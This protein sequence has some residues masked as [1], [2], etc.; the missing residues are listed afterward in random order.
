[1]SLLSDA[2]LDEGAIWEAVA[3]PGVPQLG[4]LLWVVDLNRQSLDRVVPDIPTQRL[5]G[6]FEAA[7]WQVI[8]LKWGRLI[9]EVFAQA[10]GHHLRNRLETMPNE[11][12][13]RLLRLEA[14]HLALHLVEE[15]EDDYERKEFEQLLSR[16]GPNLL[17]VAIRD[18]SGHDMEQ[19]LASFAQADDQRPTVVFAYT[20]T[21]K[22]LPTQGH[23]YN[24]STLL[25][26]QQMHQRAHDCG[27]ALEEPWQRFAPDNEPGQ[28]VRSTSAGTAA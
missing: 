6:I 18:L 9:N 26:E 22:G 24:Y 12:Y 23:P 11:E 14:D 21:G 2:E 27:V 19:L 13:Q 10:G 16:L 15:V 8:T 3:D 4:E 5:A 1:M 28:A 7:G 20:I 17:A 25:T